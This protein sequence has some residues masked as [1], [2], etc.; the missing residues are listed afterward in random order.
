[1]EERRSPIPVVAAMLALIAVGSVILQREVAD[2]MT[3]ALLLS[4]AWAAVVGL[5]FLLYARPRGMLPQVIGGLAVGAVIA[6]F[7]YY[8]FSVRDEKVDEDVVTAP[9][10]ARGAEA[11]RALEAQTAAPSPGRAPAGEAA[12]LTLATGSFTGVD[13]HNGSGRATVV[14]AADGARTVTFTDFDVD[15]GAEV[16]VWLTTGPDETEDRVELGDLKGNVG[17]Q[18]YEIPAGVDL[19]KHRTVMLYCTPFTV[20]IAVADLKPTA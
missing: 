3:G 12:N 1:M 17:N 13:G 14:G 18:Q 16:E 11:E 10:T 8:W 2:T 15:P 20:R 9:R 19:M 6:G 7:S 5:A 4:I